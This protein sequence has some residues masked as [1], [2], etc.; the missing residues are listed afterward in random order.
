M[1]DLYMEYEGISI[2]P[3]GTGICITVF[4][5]VGEPILKLHLNNS[6]IDSLKEDVKNKQKSRV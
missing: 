1:T 2:D 4:K 5:D 6:L 3:E